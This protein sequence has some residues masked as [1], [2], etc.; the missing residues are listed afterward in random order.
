MAILDKPAVFAAP[1]EAGSPVSLK[2]RYENFIGG[3]WIAPVDGRYQDNLSPVTGRAFCQ[4]PR[5]TA[6]TVPPLEAYRT[7]TS[8]RA[9]SRKVQSFNFGN[10]ISS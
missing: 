8:C 2:P 9:S 6:A 3:E 10:R 7:L 5:S 1:G 4:V